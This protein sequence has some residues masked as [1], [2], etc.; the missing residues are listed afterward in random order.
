[1]TFLLD[2]AQLTCIAPRSVGDEYPQRS[3]LV[4]AQDTTFAINNA[5]QETAQETPHFLNFARHPRTSLTVGLPSAHKVE[6]T[7]RACRHI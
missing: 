3:P 6:V 5:W 1:M 2:K 7:L 4:T